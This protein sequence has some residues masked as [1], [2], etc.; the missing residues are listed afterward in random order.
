MNTDKVTRVVVVN[1]E[2]P[3]EE[4]RGL[5]YESRNEDYKGKVSVVLQDEGRTLKV[6]ISESLTN[7][8]IKKTP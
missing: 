5:R 7:Q 8:T 2:D 4:L 6:F 3:I 1:H